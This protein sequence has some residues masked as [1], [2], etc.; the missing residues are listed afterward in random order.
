[1]QPAV[2]RLVAFLPPVAPGSL[3]RRGLHKRT[4]STSKRARRVWG[5]ELRITE[6]HEWEIAGAKIVS[7]SQAGR[8]RLGKPVHSLEQ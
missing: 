1:M 5:H 2:N 6:V 7:A 8:V 3:S 4:I